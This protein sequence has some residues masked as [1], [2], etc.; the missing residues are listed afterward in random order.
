MPFSGLGP[1]ARLPLKRVDRW[2]GIE[3]GNFFNDIGSEGNVEARLIEF[4][5]L[6]WK[7]AFTVRG[8]EFR[9]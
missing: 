9:P 1:K 4:R 2:M 5:H 7:H 3:M 8:I 6:S